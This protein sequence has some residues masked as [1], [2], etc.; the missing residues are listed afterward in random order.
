MGNEDKEIHI[1][2]DEV[3]GGESSGVVRWVLLIG[4][5]VA[6]VLLSIVWITGA[7]DSTDEEPLRDVSRQVET[8]G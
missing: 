5:A 6:I 3:R 4:T 8:A 2:T 7:A 1:E